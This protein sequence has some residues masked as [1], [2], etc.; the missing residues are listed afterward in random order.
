V[1]KIGVQNTS[2]A[3]SLKQAIRA[4]EFK[5][6]HEKLTMAGEC[7]AVHLVANGIVVASCE[8][9]VGDWQEHKTDDGQRI[10]NIILHGREF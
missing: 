4:R 8:A 10:Q 5:A 2:N 9:V 6:I 1:I 7:F 3:R